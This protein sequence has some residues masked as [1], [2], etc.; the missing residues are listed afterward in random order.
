MTDNTTLIQ[1][2]AKRL[3]KNNREISGNPSA[4]M[5]HVCEEAHPGVDHS[6]WAFGRDLKAD[7]PT[8]P[9]GTAPIFGQ[10]TKQNHVYDEI[11]KKWVP[12]SKEL[13]GIYCSWCHQGPFGSYVPYKGQQVCR[14]CWSE[15]GPARPFVK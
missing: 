4:K 12:V 14:K 3:T 11:K 15:K 5:E 13:P 7:M 8:Y 1:S 10:G 6:Q 9:G 2:F